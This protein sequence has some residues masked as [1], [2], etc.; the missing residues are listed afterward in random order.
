LLYQVSGQLNFQ[1]DSFQQI[2][3]LHPDPTK[4]SVF[5]FG[6]SVCSCCQT[7]YCWT[8]CFLCGWRV[9]LERSSCRRHFS[10]SS[11][12]FPK[13]FKTTSLFTLLSWPCLL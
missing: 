6:Q 10:T 11:A 12:H 4:A 13:T 9:C 5:H 1:Q 7:A 8:S 2:I 3:R